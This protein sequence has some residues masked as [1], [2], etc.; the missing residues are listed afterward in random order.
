MSLSFLQSFQCEV[1]INLVR[2]WAEFDVF[3][4]FGSESFHLVL[5]F[6]FVFLPK[7]NL[8]LAVLHCY[9]YSVFVSV[10]LRGG[11][12]ILWCSDCVFILGN[13]CEPEFWWCN[14]HMCSCLSS[15]YNA[16]PPLIG[17]FVFLFPFPSCSG[18]LLQTLGYGFC[19]PFPCRLVFCLLGEIGLVGISAVTA[20]SL[21]QLA[22][23]GKLSQILPDL[24]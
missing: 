4:L 12:S 8:F 6:P 11:T 22:I 14:L 23:W 18:F 16:K 19:C 24:P 1:C 7:R 9:F 5:Q 3:F 10:V 2:S 21:S 15:R 17:F 20:I 13:H